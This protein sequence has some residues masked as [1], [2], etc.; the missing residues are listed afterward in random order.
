MG[1][2]TQAKRRYLGGQAFGNPFTK[3]LQKHSK[4]FVLKKAKT[5]F[6]T[7]KGNFTLNGLGQGKTNK[8]SR[9]RC[10]Q[11]VLS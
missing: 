7:D 5:W 4:S 9:C 11:L 6:K 2:I 3:Y 8:N 1:K 10:F